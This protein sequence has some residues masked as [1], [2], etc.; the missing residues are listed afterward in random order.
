MTD[1]ER[2]FEGLILVA[3]ENYTAN[4]IKVLI[5]ARNFFARALQI[6]AT[7]LRN[8]LKDEHQDHDIKK[9]IRDILKEVEEEALRQVKPKKK[10]E[11]VKPRIIT[12]LD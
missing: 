6:H 12:R 11:V 2:I 5:R 8:M 1:E 4:P 10:L 9:A 3:S 7:V